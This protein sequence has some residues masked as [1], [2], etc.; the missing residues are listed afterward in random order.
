MSL[1]SNY[2]K[3]VKW[4]IV[5]NLL[6]FT[7]IFYVTIYDMNRLTKIDYDV[8]LMDFSELAS[9]YGICIFSFEVKN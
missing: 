3:F 9:F 7:C 4:S 6:A 1:V 2:T 8:N 5:G